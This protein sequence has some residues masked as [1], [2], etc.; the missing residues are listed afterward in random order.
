M[1]RASAIR[2]LCKITDVSPYIAL[3]L[4]YGSSGIKIKVQENKKI[5]WKP[6][7]SKPPHPSNQFL[8]PLECEQSFI[9]L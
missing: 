4:C 5:Q 2:A 8:F 6:L 1:Y 9:F 3:L 7:I